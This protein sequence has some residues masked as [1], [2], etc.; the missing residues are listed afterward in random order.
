MIT[1]ADDGDSDTYQNGFNTIVNQWPLVLQIDPNT[2]NR[3]VLSAGSNTG[4]QRGSGSNFQTPQGV[5]RENAG[6][7]VCYGFGF[8][9]SPKWCGLTRQRGTR[10]FCQVRRVGTG[11]SFVSPYGIAVESSGSFIVTDTGLNAVLR[12]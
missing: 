3:S 10:P 11:T 12:V 1:I 4:V 6:T 9:Q 5:A 7:F 8:E 2:G